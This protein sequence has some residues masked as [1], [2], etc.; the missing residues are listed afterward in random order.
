MS[1]KLFRI[2]RLPLPKSS[3]ESFLFKKMF[4]IILCSSRLSFMHKFN[5][6][7]YNPTFMVN[8]SA[9]TLFTMLL[10]VYFYLFVFYSYFY[11][12]SFLSSILFLTSFFLYSSLFFHLPCSLWGL[13]THG[14]KLVDRF[15][16]G[17]VGFFGAQ[18][19]KKFINN[20]E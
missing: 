18:H 4:F 9:I 11:I 10:L 2:Y 13:E 6:S 15:S 17:R 14:L 1:L 8:H 19:K 20:Y 16:V 7:Y 5:K 12:L 3:W